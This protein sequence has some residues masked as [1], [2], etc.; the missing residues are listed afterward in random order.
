MSHWPSWEQWEAHRQ[1]LSIY[2][3]WDVECTSC[4]FKPCVGGS[5]EPLFLALNFTVYSTMLDVF[6][7]IA[8]CKTF[9]WIAVISVLVHDNT[10][11]VLFFTHRSH[12]NTLYWVTLIHC[13]ILWSSEQ[14]PLWG[15][16]HDELDKVKQRTDLTGRLVTHCTVYILSL[17]PYH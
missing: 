16:T 3:K 11:S 2:T 12:F 1:M 17:L 4:G 13:E 10:A 5:K 6:Q 7:A 8:I 9:P 15:C 14:L